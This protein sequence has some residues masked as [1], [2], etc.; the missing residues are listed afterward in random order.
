MLLD[1]CAAKAPDPCACR[2]A[3]LQTMLVPLCDIPAA[4]QILILSGKPLEA[5]R[6]L[7]A[8][9]LPVRI[10]SVAVT[11]SLSLL[12]PLVQDCT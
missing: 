6:L 10:I 12:W 7:S 11:C 9:G 5:K 3:A 4:D 8:Y 1:M 2:V